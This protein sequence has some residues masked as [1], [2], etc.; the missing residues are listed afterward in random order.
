MYLLAL[1]LEPGRSN[2]DWTGCWIVTKFW[3][4]SKIEPI[5]SAMR[6]PTLDLPGGRRKRLSHSSVIATAMRDPNTDVEIRKVEDLRQII[7]QEME[8]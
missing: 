3:T 5:L 6:C 2:V 1:S 8:P 7:E 4:T